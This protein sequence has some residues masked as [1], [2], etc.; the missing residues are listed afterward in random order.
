MGCPSYQAGSWRRTANGVSTRGV[1][2]NSRRPIVRRNVVDEP[3]TRARASKNKVHARARGCTTYIIGIT[4]YVSEERFG[5]LKLRSGEY[6]SR[7]CPRAAPPEPII[8]TPITHASS[9]S[10][11]SSSPQRRQVAAHSYR[12]RKGHGVTRV[13]SV[14]SLC[15]FVSPVS[16]VMCMESQTRASTNAAD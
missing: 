7:Q 8:C 15:S 11:S 3:R 16:C 2:R 14:C 13:F 5:A 10:S 9:S 12:V 4:K 1:R 6:V